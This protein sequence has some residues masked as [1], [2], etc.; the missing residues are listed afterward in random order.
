MAGNSQRPE[1]SEMTSVS[2]GNKTKGDDDKKNGLL[3]NMPAK[4]K[5]GIA[6]QGDSTDECLPGW[7][8]E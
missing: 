5:G 7:L 2:E 6:A 8:R 1:G 4:E 3:M